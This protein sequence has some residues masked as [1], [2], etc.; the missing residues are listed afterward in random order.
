M[1]RQVTAHPSSRFYEPGFATAHTGFDPDEAGVCWT[2]W[3]CVT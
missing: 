3:R 2:N 1:L